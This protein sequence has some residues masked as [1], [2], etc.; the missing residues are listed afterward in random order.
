MSADS[1]PNSQAVSISRVVLG[2][3]YDGSGFSGWQQQLSPILPTVQHSCQ[4]ALSQIADE[5]VKLI[6]AGRTD[7]GVH[8]TGQIVHFDCSKD[9]G[10]KAWVK[11]S[12]SLLP[13]TVRILWACKQSDNFHAR[14]SAIARRYRYVIYQA[15]VAPAILAGKVTHVRTELDT[16]A[17]HQAAQHLVGEQ[18]FS[19]FQAAGCQSKSSNR[20]VHW[21]KVQRQGPFI[22]LDIQANAFLQHMVRNIAG[23]LLQ[24]GAGISPVEWAAELLAGKDRTK[25]AV[26]AAPDGLYL[27][28]V[29]YPS[30]FELPAAPLGPLFLAAH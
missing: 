15:A 20:N 28:Q 13:S 25:G 24:I 18:D 8:A 21:A 1:S 6:C 22:V 30:Q 11:G 4:Q 26:T 3:E 16:E 9:R 29:S 12:N 27:V 14:F 2:I 10:P 7:R 23:V 5:P 19:A 17:M